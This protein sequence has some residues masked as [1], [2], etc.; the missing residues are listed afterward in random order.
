MLTAGSGAFFDRLLP[1][2]PCWFWLI[3]CHRLSAGLLSPRRQGALPSPRQVHADEAGGPSRLDGSRWVHTDYDDSGWTTCVVA[4]P[5]G[6]GVWAGISGRC[7][8]VPAH[9]YFRIGPL[10]LPLPS[11]LELGTIT[12]PIA[13]I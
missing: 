12:V 5:G 2:T 11:P 6:Q 4:G 10:E 13:A 8:G 3:C 7:C 9:S 1:C